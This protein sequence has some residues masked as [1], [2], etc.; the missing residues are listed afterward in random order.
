M[1][2]WLLGT[3]AGRPSKL[4]NVSGAALQLP[5]PSGNWWLIDAGEATQHQLLRTPLK[6]S[7]L[8]LVLITH[9]HGDHLYGLPGLLSSRSF[10]G[11]TTPLTLI[12]PIGLKS[13]IE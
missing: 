5:E 8:E 2:L 11:G 6:L 4:R 13:Y 9:L 7:K 10:S 12:G 3:G 1:K